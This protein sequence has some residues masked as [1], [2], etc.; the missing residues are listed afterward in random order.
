MTATDLRTVAAF[1]TAAPVAGDI[2]IPDDATLVHIFIKVVNDS[3]T[4]GV[5][6]SRRGD[7]KAFYTVDGKEGLCSWDR[8]RQVVWVAHRLPAGYKLVI[9]A[10]P[11]SQ[12]SGLLVQNE[13]TIVGPGK[14]VRSEPVRMPRVGTRGTWNYNI[15]LRATGTNH[16]LASI[17]PDIDVHPDP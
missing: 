1:K 3:L 13:Y 15:F 5:F 8:P 7:T 11:D 16:D 4:F 17:D 9:E 10:K 6:P 2:Q 14:F 12:G